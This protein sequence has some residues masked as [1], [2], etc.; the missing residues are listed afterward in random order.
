VLWITMRRAISFFVACNLVA[1]GRVVFY[2]DV[3]EA[4]RFQGR[5]VMMGGLLV[6]VGGAWLC[7]LRRTAVWG[8][9]AD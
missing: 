8:S 5:L 3:F 7:K 1:L 6:A 2:L 4:T 9:K